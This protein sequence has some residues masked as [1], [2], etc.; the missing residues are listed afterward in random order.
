MKYS[1][2]ISFLFCGLLTAASI[3]QPTFLARRD[4]PSAGQYVTVGDVNGDGIPD[5]IA[6]SV[7]YRVS[8]MLGKG[9]VTFRSAVNSTLWEFQYG[10]I[11]YDL[12]GDGKSDL[13]LSGY[14]NEGGAIGICCS[15]GDGTFQTPVVYKVEDSNLGHAVVGDFN[16]DGIPD[17]AAPG[18]KGIWLFTGKGAGVFNPGVL[19]ASAPTG[20]I[21]LAS[22]DFHG[23]GKLDLAVGVNPSGLYTVF[24]N[25][26]GTFTAP[27]K[28]SN[29][30]EAY[31]IAGDAIG[32]GR[33][34]IIVPSAT[35]YVN[36][37]VG[38]FTKKIDVA[39][40]GVSEWVAVGD[41]NGDGIPDL[42][43]SS[44]CV[45]LRLGGGQF[46]PAVCNTVAGAESATSGVIL[47]NLAKGKKGFDDLVAGVNSEVSVLLN[48][49]NGSF[50]DGEWI[51]VAGSGNCAAAG[52]FNGDGHPDLAIPT[53]NGL[54]ILLG[55]GE[56]AD[57]YTT[58]VTIPLSGP[59]CPIS[60]D[61]NNDGIVDLLEGA[62]SLGGVGVY[63]GNGDG[64][65][66]LASVVPLGPSTNMVLG[67]FN[68]DGKREVATTSNQLALGNGDG[69]FQSPVPILA[70]LPTPGYM[71]W[72][73]A[74]DIN[75]DGWTDLVYVAEIDGQ[76]LYVL[77]NDQ[78]GGFTLNIIPDD[79][80]GSAVMLGDLTGNGILDAVVTSEGAFA[81]IY[82]GNGKGGFTLGQSGI[83]YPFVDQ[84]PVQIGDVN[85]DGIPDL[86]LPADGSI[87]IALGK[88]DGSFVNP[89]VVGAG[90]GLGQ[91]LFETLHGQAP[92]LP[93]LVAPDSSGGAV[94][95]INATK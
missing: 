32:N 36:N 80:G 45:A 26:D 92:G 55:T 13:I 59:G 62:D 79:L 60:G 10:A 57:P 11:I 54:V 7:Q 5:I 38:V 28:I 29:G 2:S 78:N 47:A 6:V 24:G 51:P 89:F 91:V 31:I 49:G 69:T 90:P 34:D 85:G 43:S 25:G 77:L 61:V 30:N 93:D 14:P 50:V 17:I 15:N 19:A 76:G 39:M 3:K 68:H 94:V 95:L 58:G 63:L 16:G 86:L 33:A 84:L 70:S 81:A 71:V 41:V 64:T 74:G 72:I 21:W 18:G 35:V 67:D 56:A 4:Y 12:N 88:G 75:N 65:F 22:A 9:D 53:T 1:L 48:K 23:D 37:G 42:A 52:D 66:Q 82:Q 20:G 40:S 27:T 8:V 87:G 83:S 73:A 44:G 46:A